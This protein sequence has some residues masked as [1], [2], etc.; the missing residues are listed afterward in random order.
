MKGH[1]IVF[2]IFDFYFL[3]IPILGNLTVRDEKGGLQE[4]WLMCY[5]GTCARIL[6]NYATFRPHICYTFK[7]SK[8]QILIIHLF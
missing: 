7:S 1:D 2:Q 3:K 4:T 6:L 8:K 5:I